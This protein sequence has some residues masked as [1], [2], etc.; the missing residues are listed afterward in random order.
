M[1]PGTFST[2]P[3]IYEY[4]KSKSAKKENSIELCDLL[5][6][7]SVTVSVFTVFYRI[8]NISFLLLQV[9]KLPIDDGH[10][11]CYLIKVVRK[12]SK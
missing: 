2:F 10:F 4:E 12:S 6:F 7:I 1:G 8:L 5:N 11:A 9:N 3:D